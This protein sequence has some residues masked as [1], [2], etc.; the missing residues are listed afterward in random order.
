M[1]RLLLLVLFAACSCVK[2]EE[3]K[4]SPY[5]TAASELSDAYCELAFTEGCSVPDDC[6]LP[7]AFDSVTDCDVNLSPFLRSCQVPDDEVDSIINQINQCVDALDT[8]TCDEPL[9]GGGALDTNPCLGLFNA[10]SE[11]CTFERL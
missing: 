5:K 8:Q 6:G 3:T 9:C 10:L 4:D 11:Y 2:G 7:G 1:H